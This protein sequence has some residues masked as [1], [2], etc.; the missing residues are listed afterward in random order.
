METT[1]SALQDLGATVSNRDPDYGVLHA[2]FVPRY[3]AGVAE[4]AEEIVP[5]RRMLEPRTRQLAMVGSKVPAKAV[6]AA[7]RSAAKTAQRFLA[8]FDDTDVLVMPVIARPAARIGGWMHKG[9]T[10]T[11]AGAGKWVPFCM[12]WNVVGFPALSFPVGLSKDG[13]PLAVQLV[14]P[15]DGDRLL[16]RVAAALERVR[17]PFPRPTLS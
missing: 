6:T 3:L 17:G 10:G 15:P 14:A 2:G 4:D 16:L 11:A 13:L 12:P 5:D 1:L 7:H 8:L 9:L